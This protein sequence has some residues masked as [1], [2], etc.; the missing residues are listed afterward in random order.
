[1]R[2][3]GPRSRAVVS[4]KR[5]SRLL[6]VLVLGVVIQQG[7]PLSSAAGSDDCASECPDDAEDG[8]CPPDCHDCPCCA[9][10]RLTAPGAAP[11]VGRPEAGALSPLE[12]P[13]AP[14]SGDPSEVFHVP[15]RL[16]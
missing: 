1:M 4:S 8:T 16:L 6:T 10:V 15:K 14:D 5:L 3:A 7:A 12:V 2:R 11:T 13:V 9:I